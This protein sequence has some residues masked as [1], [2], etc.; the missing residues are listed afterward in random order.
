MASDLSLAHIQDWL[1][2]ADELAAGGRIDLGQVARIDSSGAAFLLELTRRA[3]KKGAHLEFANAS[4]Q[5][6][7]L[8]EFLQIDSVLK[9]A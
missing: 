3:Q 9:L 8:L 1:A 2:R 7:S 4:P 6:R 5:V